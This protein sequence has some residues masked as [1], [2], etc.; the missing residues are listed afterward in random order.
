MTHN[1]TVSNAIM[2]QTIKNSQTPEFDKNKSCT[3]AILFQ[4]PTA[5]E[6]RPTLIA[7][8]KA[9]L[10]DFALVAVFSAVV[11]IPTAFAVMHFAGA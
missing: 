7:Q 5:Q 4:S 10:K 8:I 3:T 11:S 6:Q 9:D 1:F 2:Q